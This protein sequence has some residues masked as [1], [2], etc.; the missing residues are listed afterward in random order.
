MVRH[1][2]RPLESFGVNDPTSAAKNY[3]KKAA[4]EKKLAQWATQYRRMLI[5]GHTHRPVFPAADRPP[6]FNDG[7][8]IHPG[9]ITA[10]EIKDGA[11]EL[12]K[13]CVKV[14]PDGILHVGRDSLA[15]PAPL[16]DYFSAT[17]A[18]I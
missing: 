13:W 11:I 7:S 5:A 14:R 9:C 1:L 3:H 17:L 12:V 16:T 10:I 2:W 18:G 4:T 15:G 6:Y 8:C